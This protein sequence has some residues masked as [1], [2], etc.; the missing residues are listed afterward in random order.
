MPSF[1][2]ASPKGSKVLEVG[3][4]K[5]EPGL[6]QTVLVQ[7]SNDLA[8]S[9]VLSLTSC[10]TLDKSLNFYVFQLLLMSDGD[11]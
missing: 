6:I 9:L 7:G 2:T 10:M 4:N 11:A 5:K 8:P 3:N 1:I